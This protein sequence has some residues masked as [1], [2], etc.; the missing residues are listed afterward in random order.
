MAAKCEPMELV[1]ADVEEIHQGGVMQALGP[2]QGRNDQHGAGRPWPRAPG[3][4]HPR[5]AA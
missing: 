3:I 4:P 5:R 1:T 2:A